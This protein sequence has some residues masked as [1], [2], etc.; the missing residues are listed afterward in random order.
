[1]SEKAKKRIGTF[2]RYCK[3][4]LS[5]LEHD[6]Y[7]T[8]PTKGFGAERY[9]CKE[10]ANNDHKGRGGW[11]SYND[12]VDTV[13]G[14][15][16]KSKMQFAIE[17]ECEY[18]E[19]VTV[20]G[21]T[22]YN[23]IEINA[24]MASQYHLLPTHDSTVG[25][26]F[27]EERRR[28]LHGYKQRIQGISETVNLTPSNCGHH[29]NIS[30]TTWDNRKYQFLQMYSR[31]LFAPLANFL[32]ENKD[33]TKKVFGR[34]FSG[35]CEYSDVT[36]KHGYWL[37]IRNNHEKN[38]CC[39]EFRLAKFH[40]V[41]QFFYLIN[42]CKDVMLLVDEFLNNDE[43]DA[44]EVGLEIVGIFKKYASGN[45]LCMRKERNAKAR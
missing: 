14:L 39:L 35:W 10:C 28:S 22:M 42:F 24:Y 8:I 27:K 15:E 5:C 33:L 16:T 2:C 3:K 4:D 43:L 30:K 11:E 6:E 20:N 37:N 12:E 7:I 17:Y 29:I 36:F 26:E 13:I 9:V 31:N 1:M 32:Y 44:D 34:D 38:E 41:D 25:C 45:A 19:Y 23:P 40:D 18:N 21:I